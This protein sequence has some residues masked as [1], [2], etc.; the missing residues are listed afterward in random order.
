MPGMINGAHVIVYSTNPEEDRRFLRDVLELT[1]VDAGGGWLIFGLPPSEVAV[2]PSEGSEKHE[3]YL[4]CE[5]IEAFMA[6]MGQRNIAC[7]PVQEQDWG[8]LTDVIL[9]GGGRLGVYE[10]RHFRPPAAAG[11]AA[12][13]KRKA[14]AA[15]KPARKPA[16]KRRAAK[17]M[18][19]KAPAKKR[20]A[21]KP[22][23]KKGRR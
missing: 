19:K 23:K 16:P 10:P 5:D 13:P 12:R 14:A 2:H 21:M 8:L 18:A 17:Q 4:M 6:E 1:H 22:A 11:I 9:P 3:L 7:N 15:A 20:P